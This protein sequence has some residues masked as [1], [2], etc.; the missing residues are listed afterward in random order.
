M[1][2]GGWVHRSLVLAVAPRA[3]HLPQVDDGLSG[4]THPLHDDLPCRVALQRLQRDRRLL[5]GHRHLLLLSRLPLARIQ[6]SP[7]GH[8][9][10]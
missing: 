3:D 2:L 4:R 6:V 1:R 5:G 7:S 8:P 10:L 9:H